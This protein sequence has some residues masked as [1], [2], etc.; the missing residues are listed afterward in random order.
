MYMYMYMVNYSM[1]QCTHV[2]VHVWYIHVHVHVV[3]ICS[4]TY[5]VL[6]STIVLAVHFTCKVLSSVMC[7]VLLLHSIYQ[8]LI[9]C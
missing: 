3:C 6:Y 1:A 8:L 4:S 2:H 7:V 5:T 9:F